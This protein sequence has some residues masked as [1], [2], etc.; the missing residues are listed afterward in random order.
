MVAPLL[1]GTLSYLTVDPVSSKLLSTFART[2]NCLTLITL[3][4]PPSRASDLHAT[5]GAIL[6][7]FMID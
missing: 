2:R 6:M 3:T 1:S 7:C 4:T 5:H